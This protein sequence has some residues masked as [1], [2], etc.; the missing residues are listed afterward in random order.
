MKSFIFRWFYRLLFFALIFTACSK[1][2]PTSPG[3]TEEPTDPPVEEADATLISIKTAQT[4]QTMIGF[5]GA[6]TWNSVRITNSSRKNEII[7]IIVDDLGVDM[8]RLKNWYYPVNYPENKAPDEME[9]S[10]HKGL[11]NATNELY[12]LIKSKN[13]DIEILF[14]SWGPHSAL[15]SNNQLFHG[16]LKKQDGEF[17]YDAFATYWEDVLNHITFVPDYVSIQNEPTWVADWETCEWRP[18]ETEEF[19]SYE[20]AFDRVAEKLNTLANPPIMV[21]PESANLSYN[22]FDAFALEL[23]DNPNLGVYAYHPYNF[24]D[25]STLSEMQEMLSDLGE[26]FSDKPKIMTEYDGLEWMKTARFINSTLREANTS[27]YLYWTLMWDE[28]NEHAMIQVDEIGNYELTKFYH[29]IKHY[30]K[31]VDKGYVRVDVSSEDGSLDQVA[32]LNPGGDELTVISINPSEE[33][34]NVKFEIEGSTLT[35]LIS[36]QSLE[37][38]P[39]Y[40]INEDNHTVLTLK[41]SS[42]TTTVLNLN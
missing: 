10:W 23:K 33:D 6:L 26:N 40:S 8:V 35:P 34:V 13:P 24:N 42:I 36:Y 27:A 1:E 29:L 15:K 18:S 7:E 37:T 16:T 11:F 17:M 12:D 28:N 39:F 3:E 2:N 32:F 25:N 5:G 4:H 41:S 14:S 20:I 21:G 9:I 30:A 38:Q 31:Y 19:P 22:G